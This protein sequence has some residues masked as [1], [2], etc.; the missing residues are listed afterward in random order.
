V[1][2]QLI[3]AAEATGVDH[4]LQLVLDVADHNRAAIAFWK[5]HGWR[6]VGQAT[7]PPGDEGH[8]LRLLLLVASGTS[9]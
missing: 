2:T 4:G 5:E 7:L 1:A 6:E 8:Q 3:N 9:Q